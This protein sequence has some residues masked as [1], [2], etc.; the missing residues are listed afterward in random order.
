MEESLPKLFA[1]LLSAMVVS[2]APCRAETK[3]PVLD[4]WYPALFSAD[5]PALASLLTEDAEIRLEDIG[6][7][8][9][10]SEFLDSL[11]EWKDSIEGASFDWKLDPAAPAT[12]TE[13][14]ALVCYRF[15]SNELYTREV[16]TF[17]ENKIVKSVQ[18]TEGESCEGF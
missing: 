9:T 15:P 8:Q 6:I 5:A 13:A 7:T 12:D 1:L 4:K 16:F 10:K 14:T 11:G 2:T 3:T 18:T 17:A